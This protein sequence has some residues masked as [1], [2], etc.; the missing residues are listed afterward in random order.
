MLPLL[1][2]H[3]ERSLGAL[4]ARLEG[5]IAVDL[6][7]SRCADILITPGADIAYDDNVCGVKSLPVTVRWT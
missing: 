6:L 5:T 4:R 7:R 2:D 1:R 3:N